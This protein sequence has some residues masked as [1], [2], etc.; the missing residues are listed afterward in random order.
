MFTVHIHA[1]FQ[2]LSDR[3]PEIPVVPLLGTK[4]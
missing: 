2:V 3:V 4:V 1:V